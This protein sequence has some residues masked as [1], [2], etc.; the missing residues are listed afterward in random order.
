MKSLNNPDNLYK[1]AWFLTYGEQAFEAIKNAYE[2]EI[3]NL[4][5]DIGKKVVVKRDNKKI[6]NIN[7][8]F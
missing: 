8:L 6:D 7:D 4:K 5:K 1:A 3:T 2:T